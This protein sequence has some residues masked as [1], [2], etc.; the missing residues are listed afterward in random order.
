MNRTAFSLIALIIFLAACTTKEKVMPPV[1]NKISKE[2]TI[3]GDTRI[4]NYY[5]MKDRENPGVIAHLEAENTYTEAVMK[6]T[7]P[8]QNKLF[9]EIKSKIKQEDESAP[10]KKKGYFYYTRT[11]PETEY[12]LVCRKKEPMEAG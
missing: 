12:Y 9:D 1:A 4:D 11:V 5:W 10:Y 3:H 2:L 6:H 7:Q 8:L